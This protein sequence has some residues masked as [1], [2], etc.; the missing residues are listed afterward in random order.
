MS[1]TVPVMSAP[2]PIGRRLLLQGLAA[3]LLTTPWHQALAA[4]SGNDVAFLDRL[5]WGATPQSLLELQKLGRSAWLVRQLKPG[6]LGPLPG[7]VQAQ[8]D[9]L[10]LTRQPFDQIVRQMDTLWRQAQREKGGGR[11][12]QARAG[13]D[14]AAPAASAAM[15]AQRKAPGERERPQGARRDFQQY[16]QQLHD[17]A[18]I[19]QLQRALHA[20]DQLRE[21]M[22]WFWFNHFNILGHGGPLPGLLG[23]Y[24]HR[25]IRTHA[26]GRFR[27]ML[28]AVVTHPAMLIYLNN[29]KNVA[30]QLNENFARELME[31][32]TLGV[33]GG[34]TQADVQQLARI[35]TGLGAH[36]RPGQVP[37]EPGAQSFTLDTARFN[38]SRHDMGDKQLLGQRIAGQGWPEIERTLDLL[39]R[40]PSTARYLSRKMAR[41]LVADEPPD[42][43]V[44]RMAVRFQET[45]GDIA[46]VLA[47]LIESPEFEASLDKKFK[48]PIH[49]LVSALRLTAPEP[50]AIADI[51][52]AERWLD[53]MGQRPFG[54][55]TPDG[56]SLTAAEWN[57]SGQMTARF[58]VAR[59]L[60][61][62]AKGLYDP[63]P[64][65]PRLQDEF[66]RQHIAPGLSA[67]TRAAL[68][69]AGA[70]ADWATTWLSSPEFMTR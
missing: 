7:A 52:A 50:L 60:A 66:F 12:A 10:V 53:R 39:A 67:A 22:S 55:A 42:A 44:Q 69:D 35:L 34:Y 23:D 38:P 20:P 63:A 68:A 8:I 14:M 2:A 1:T 28:Q 19:R 13:A 36:D 9:S 5:S 33:D 56:Y 46:A 40:H 3:G 15:A 70:P 4:S 43:L 11:A 45:D 61:M 21:Q 62:G 64:A 57:G 26:L 27:D 49:Y 54:R 41:Y 30:R 29:T 48:D 31:L 37:L 59:Q 24:E 47:V 65:R 18:L 32:H 25:A 16:T 58:E 17:E 51:K 6:P